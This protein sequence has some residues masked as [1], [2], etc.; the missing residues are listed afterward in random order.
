[1][2]S[3]MGTSVNK[4]SEVH[5]RAKLT[6]RHLT[7]YETRKVRIAYGFSQVGGIS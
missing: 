1:M 5:R 3:E 4:F 2:L 7:A 6:H